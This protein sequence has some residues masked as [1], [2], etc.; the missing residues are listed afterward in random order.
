MV[1]SSGRRRRTSDGEA[2]QVGYGGQV[3][4]EEGEVDQ[5]GQA[6]QVGRCEDQVGD[7]GQVGT[8][9]RGDQVGDAGQVGTRRRGDQVGGAGQV[10][11]QV[12]V[13]RSVTVNQPPSLLLVTVVLLPVPSLPYSLPH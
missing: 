9:R 8:R 6:S 13:G 12:Q 11:G 4:V 1:Q 7:A 10:E 3:G 5:V 2:G